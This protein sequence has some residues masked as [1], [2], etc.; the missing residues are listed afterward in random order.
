MSKVEGEINDNI[1]NLKNALP[2]AK[3]PEA[4]ALAELKGT[5]PNIK[6][7]K[8]V[9][10]SKTFVPEKFLKDFEEKDLLATIG[11]PTPEIKL[12]K[13]SIGDKFKKFDFK[14]TEPKKEPEIDVAKL[15]AEGL[16][17][18]QIAEAQ[19]QR[20][21]K[22]KRNEKGAQILNK[23]KDTAAGALNG[24]VGG[25]TGG[26][27]QALGS[28][29]GTI[30]NFGA[31]ALTNVVS[32]FLGGLGGGCG[33]TLASKIAAFMYFKA[34]FGTIKERAEGVKGT[35]DG[36]KDIG[37]DVM[38]G[39]TLAIGI[40][41]ILEGIEGTLKGT[42]ETL[43]SA[44]APMK[45]T[46]PGHPGPGN[47]ANSEVSQKSREAR[48]KAKGFAENLKQ[49]V[50]NV[51]KVFKG[52][53]D[54]L[55]GLLGIIFKVIGAILS[56]ISFIAFLKQMAE[57]LMLIFMKTDACA[58]RGGDQGGASSSADEFLTSIG[59]PGFGPEDFSTE[60]ENILNEMN[61][62][63]IPTIPPPNIAGNFDIGTPGTIPTP[64]IIDSSTGVGTTLGGFNLSDP[65]MFG[66]TQIGIPLTQNDL[67]PQESG[68][69]FDHH[70]ILG[71]CSGI[72]P[73]LI[74]ELYE[75]GILPK[76][77]TKD[78]NKL[79]TSQYAADLDK[80][81]EDTLNEFN[82]FQQ[83]EYIERLYNLNF[84]MIGYRRYYGQITDNRGNNMV[85]KNTPQDN[86]TGETNTTVTPS[87]NTGTPSSGGSTSRGGSGY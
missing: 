87:P 46:S 34:Q 52:I 10:G 76:I 67:I 4:A 37:K 25:I 42:A 23:L 69:V 47:K 9:M 36:L 27:D 16:T 51:G 68:K 28:I 43:K 14:K 81:Y 24:I 77:N 30:N 73:Q 80:L 65:I 18:E 15:K 56:V 74:N 7:I 11:I 17:D 72:H 85:Q 6:S 5:L 58:N 64:S 22:Q 31:A 39:G 3:I 86:N 35:V 53:F 63:T 83:L 66:P 33:P 44:T 26:I 1:G 62:P 55:K 20:E 32:G 40:K 75:D 78:P 59:Y 60:I 8:N 12:P 2:G 50:N 48:D 84:D 45:P 57:L 61:I 49:T 71:D 13:I 38:K 21:I 54:T 79:D 29:E 70:P 82:E 19:R 41:G